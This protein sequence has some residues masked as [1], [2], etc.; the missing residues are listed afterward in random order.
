VAQDGLISSVFFSLYVNDVPTPSCH[1]EL[2]QYVDD[3]ALI[4]TS[5]SPLLLI[6]YAEAYLG[7]L[8][9]WLWDW[10]IAINVSKSTTLLF[11]KAPETHP[12]T[13]T[14]AVSWRTNTVG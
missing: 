10:R 12:K 14:S 11:V 8:K 13:Q 6:S 3:M 5:R 7:R 1:V 4:A 9:C 2:A